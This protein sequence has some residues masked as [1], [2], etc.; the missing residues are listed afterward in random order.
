MASRRSW[1]RAAGKRPVRVDGRPASSTRPDTWAG[2][3]DVLAST[4]G[5]GFGIMLGGGLGCYDFD[6]VSDAEARAL[7][8]S[9]PEPVVFAERSV[10]GRGVHVFVL[11][12]EGPGTRR[13]NVERYTR[14]RFV[15]V[16][17]VGFV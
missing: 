12:D 3:A 6:H 16:T 10:S 11:A 7:V 9:I 14:G 2:F 17:G 13:G 1:V 5:D 4:A 8:A 15:R